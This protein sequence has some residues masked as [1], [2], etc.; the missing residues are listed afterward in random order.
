MKYV[1]IIL[2]ISNIY[3]EHVLSHN[4][5]TYDVERFM[6]IPSYDALILS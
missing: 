3:D 2:K 5:I 1:A 4:V 6:T